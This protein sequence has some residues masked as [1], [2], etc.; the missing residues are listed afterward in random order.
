MACHE[1][2]LSLAKAASNGGNEWESNPTRDRLKP[3]T[4]FEDQEHHQAPFT[5]F[6]NCTILSESD[7]KFKLEAYPSKGG[8]F[9]QKRIRLRPCALT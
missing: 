6:K 2:G 1:Q 9:R 5:P 3:H 7:D 8:G 4:G